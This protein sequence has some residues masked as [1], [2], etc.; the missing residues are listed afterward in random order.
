MLGI[1]VAVMA[2]VMLAAAAAVVAR[3]A[4]LLLKPQRLKKYDVIPA[5]AR[6]VEQIQAMLYVC[7][8]QPYIVDNFASEMRA[9]AETLSNG[10]I[11]PESGRLTV[12]LY[13]DL[14]DGDFTNAKVHIN[15]LAKSIKESTW[16]TK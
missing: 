4:Q 8:R 3:C 2:A 5:P 10:S 16:T 7:E 9:I 13:S 14:M 12:A 15:E 1:P 6:T 11:S